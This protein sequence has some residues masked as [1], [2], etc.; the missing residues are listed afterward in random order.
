MAG[1]DRAMS[2]RISII[3]SIKGIFCF[4]PIAL[5]FNKLRYIGMLGATHI[6]V[7]RSSQLRAQYAS[8][9]F[10]LN[11]FSVVTSRVRY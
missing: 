5:K 3:R 11:E 6:T 4:T 10:T 1:L 8:V 7:D 9:R 2:S